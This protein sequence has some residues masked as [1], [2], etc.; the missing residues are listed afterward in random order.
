VKQITNGIFSGT[1]AVEVVVYCRAR[2]REKW[3][4]EHNSWHCINGDLGGRDRVLRRSTAKTS[5]SQETRDT[6]CALSHSLGSRQRT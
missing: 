5:T 4:T 1:T 6:Y 3:R 2:T